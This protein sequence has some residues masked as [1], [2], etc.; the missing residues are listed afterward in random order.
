M[1]ILRLQALVK[2][3][4]KVSNITQ[5]FVGITIWST[6]EI[7][8]GIICACLPTLRILL[9]RLF[10]NILGTSQ[11]YYTGQTERG[12]AGYSTNRSRA[13]GSHTRTAKHARTSQLPKD[14]EGIICTRTYGIELGDNDE[15]HLVSMTD[16]Q[17]PSSR[18]NNSL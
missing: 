1:S 13:L 2:F 11:Q 4:L 12:E 3:S 10:P 16:L 9:A 8:V 15:T 14:T 18:S 17:P 6:I 7:N 5:E